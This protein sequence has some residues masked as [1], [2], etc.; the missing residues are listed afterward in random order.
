MEYT[1]LGLTELFEGCELVPYQDVN[2]TWTDGYGN[3]HNVD[4]SVTITLEQAQADLARNIQWAVTTVQR[5]VTAPLTQGEFNALVDFV[6]NIG[7]GAFAGSTMLRDLNASNYAGAASQFEAWD[8]A[9][10]RVVAGLLRR[11][12][13][14]ED[15]F[16]G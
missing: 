1:G 11:R 16:N 8:R 6:F 9:G 2:G 7:S 4:P 10:G 14:E 3:T 12:V 5:C 15:E 13:A